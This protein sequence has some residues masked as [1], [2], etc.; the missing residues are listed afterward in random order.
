E[1]IGGYHH[2]A[3]GILPHRR[4]VRWLDARIPRSDMSESLRN[5]TGSIGTVSNISDHFE[6]IERF[7]GSIPASG[8]L[9]ASDPDVEDPVAFAMEKHLEEFLVTNWNQTELAKDFSIYEEDGELVGQQ[10]A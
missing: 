1:V 6:E 10:Y 9:I 8:K 4:R 2:V 5:S 7:V 3:E